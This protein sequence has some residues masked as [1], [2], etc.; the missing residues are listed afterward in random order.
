[1]IKFNNLEIEPPSKFGLEKKFLLNTGEKNFL[2]SS[3]G[4]FSS[5]LKVK[6]ENG[7]IYA[8]KFPLFV[9]NL[10]GVLAFNFNFSENYLNKVIL[11]RKHENF[12]ANEIYENVFVE[13]L[14]G[15]KYSP[16]FKPEGVY[17]VYLNQT[18]NYLPAFV[19]EFDETFLPLNEISS[20]ERNPLLRFQQ[21]IVSKLELEGFT[22]DCYDLLIDSNW[23]YSEKRDE[24]KII[25]FGWWKYKNHFNP[26]PTLS[27]EFF[28]E[29]Y[30]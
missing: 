3:L 4:H 1:M 6:D 8:G 26:F 12:I 7:K 24:L 20:K 22:S 16:T 5:V 14:E 25:D 11:S 29:D 19:N 13:N 27:E 10:G 15:K 17:G 18:K 30:F 21:Q 23:L 9:N 28:R 2:I